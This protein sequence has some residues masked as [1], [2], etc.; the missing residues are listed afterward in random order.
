MR[1]RLITIGLVLTVLLAVWSTPA[2][3]QGGDPD[4]AATL[5]ADPWAPVNFVWVLLATVLVFFMQAGFALVEAGLTRAKNTVN[6]LTKNLLDFCIAALAFFA[7]GFAL[8]FGGSGAPGL[9]SG[10]AFIGT[11][12]FFLL[13]AAYDVNTILLWLFQMVFAATAATIISG[14]MAERTKVETYLAYSFLV[15]ALIYPVYGHW[16]WGGGWLGELGAVDFAGS[17][18]VHA[19]GGVLALIGAWKLGPRKGRFDAEGRPQTI[20]AHNVVYVVLGV[21]ILFFGWFGFNAGSTLAATELRISIIA[22]NTALAGVAG[23]VL[24]MYVGLMRTGRIDVLAT[25]NGILAGLVAVTAPCAFIA[26][27]AAIVIGAIGG[28]IML[29]ATSFTENTLKID[30]PVGAFAVHGATGIWG[31]L[32]VAIFADGTY[33]DVAGLV[34]GSTSLIV[35]QVVS[36]VALLVWTGVV[37]FVLF[38]LLDKTM[39]L[40][41]PSEDEEKGLDVTEHGYPAYVS[42]PQSA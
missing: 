22:A 25:C 8:M 12:G 16:V 7:F 32:S 26:P 3:A 33:G 21:F 13:N 23:G 41:V 19:V 29:W 20:P 5:A 35:P 1:K 10:N 34:A 18:V 30:D 28:A 9:E 17:G 38:T 2:F 24:V 14:A 40:R 31:V 4:G 37:G 42:E 11:S 15:S 27:W 39:G 6:I 36:V